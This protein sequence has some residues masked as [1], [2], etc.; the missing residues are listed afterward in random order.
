MAKGINKNRTKKNKKV[1]PHSEV[2]KANSYAGAIDIYL[3][4]L[5]NTKH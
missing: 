4:N 2:L 1:N 5:S 3:I